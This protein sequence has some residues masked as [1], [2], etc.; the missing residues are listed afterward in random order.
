MRIEIQIKSDKK[1][2]DVRHMSFKIFEGKKEIKANIG[3][4]TFYFSDDQIIN[5]DLPQFGRKRES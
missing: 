3:K 5:L 1:R 4:A 2:E